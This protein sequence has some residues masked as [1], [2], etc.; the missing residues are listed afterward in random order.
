MAKKKAEK[1]GRFYI[2]PVWRIRIHEL[3]WQRDM[4]SYVSVDMRLI[5]AA[6]AG[7]IGYDTLAF[8]VWRLCHSSWEPMWESVI[9][10]R[11]GLTPEQQRRIRRELAAEGAITVI[12]LGR[13]TYTVW[14]PSVMPEE[15]RPIF[16]ASTTALLKRWWSL[17]KRRGVKHAPDV[18]CAFLSHYSGSVACR[19]TLVFRD[20]VLNLMSNA[21]NAERKAVGLWI[22][23]GAAPDHFNWETPGNIAATLGLSRPYVSKLFKILWS[24]GLVYYSDATRQIGVS[25][26]PEGV[27]PNLHPTVTESKHIPWNTFVRG[28]T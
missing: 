26:F 8:H 1:L 4:P 18:V 23:L 14:H 17:N 22:V 15:Q 19:T 9:Q 20:S 2:Q 28:K 6:K 11:L 24:K 12:R 21:T 10:K 3:D 7:R 27:H 13:R 25:R 16:F 5:D